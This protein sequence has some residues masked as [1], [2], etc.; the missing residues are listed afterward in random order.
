VEPI[1]LPRLARIVDRAGSGGPLCIALPVVRLA[2]FIGTLANE[3]DRCGLSVRVPEARMSG[4]SDGDVMGAPPATEAARVS[5]VEADAVLILGSDGRIRASNVAAQRL[6]GYAGAELC[7]RSFTELMV[8]LGPADLPGVD[9][10]AEDDQ[11]SHPGPVVRV[12]R[13]ASGETVPV[14]LTVTWLGEMEFACYVAV[15]RHPRQ[16][17]HMDEAVGRL[18][19]L[20]DLI[21]DST[22]EAIFSIDRDG[23][24][25]SSN[26][27]A[28][29]LLGYSSGEL[30]GASI[31][32]LVHHSRADGSPYP[33]TECQF[34][35]GLSTGRTL[36]LPGE[37][38][39]RRDGTPMPVTMSFAPI[40]DDDSV[41][42]AVQ[43]FV[44][45]SEHEAVNKIKDEFLS[46][47]SHELR[48]PLTS[49]RGSLGLLA[50]GVF[51]PLDPEPAKMVD[52]AIHNTDRLVRLV[53]QILDLERMKTGHFALERHPTDIA[54]LMRS[55]VEGLHGVAAATEVE[56]VV[57]PLS[58]Q[59]VVDPDRIAQALTNVLGNAVK[60][61]PSGGRVTL[62]AKAGARKVVLRVHDE[63]RGIP[64]ER[65][66]HIFE[67]FEQVDA[68]DARDKG[69]IGLGLPIAR[70][71]AEQHG[72][73]LWADSTLG[74]GSTFYLE[75]PIAVPPEDSTA[76]MPTLLLWK[77][78]DASPGVLRALAERGYAA[79]LVSTDAEVRAALERTTPAAIVVALGL[80]DR[81]EPTVLATAGAAADAAGIPLVAVGELAPGAGPA[82][83]LSR[84]LEQVGLRPWLAHRADESRRVLIVEDD[85]DMAAV[86]TAQLRGQGL[87]TWTAATERVAIS[88]AAETRPDAIVL[89]LGLAEGDGFGVV[90]GL[91]E[92]G[93][94]SDTLLLVYS[95][96]E[97]S[98]EERDQL[99]TRETVFLVKSRATTADVADRI[100]SLLGSGTAADTETG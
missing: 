6:F 90:R 26:R 96:R 66:D 91:R 99:R 34:Y 71:I 24:I 2:D 50:G 3:A 19:R 22:S 30:L 92:Q 43:T 93:R 13:T 16:R 39:W 52:I 45:M 44:D 77:S 33:H 1:R 12:G 14:E 37:T 80:G 36:R 10:S 74:V 17:H 40:R 18:Q 8:E 15:I 20:N 35:Q 79:V 76:R 98:P 31:H 75:L 83:S 78:E 86:L 82:D 57:K 54:A 38:V 25:T 64:P 81:V 47:V 9:R 49:I 61:S 58:L 5:A 4:T 63:G 85:P 28:S 67:P 59:V 29:R 21:L 53:N 84:A 48:T 72:G 62:D 60:F 68:S 27:S 7:N 88:L 32:E 23:R 100:A 94:L 46:L 41:I 97:L 65:L 11:Q 69:G 55:S 73:R 56:L 70:S 87:C 95:V 89:D 42:G 51:G